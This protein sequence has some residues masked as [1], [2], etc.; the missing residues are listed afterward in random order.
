[1]MA[2]IASERSRILF[3]EAGRVVSCEGGGI[4]QAE[5]SIDECGENNGRTL[6]YLHAQLGEM[7]IPIG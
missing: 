4:L 5:L 7:T 1:M 2:A 3:C 6:E